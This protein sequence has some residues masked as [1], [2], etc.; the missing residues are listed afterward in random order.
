MP[1]KLSF[2]PLGSI[3]PA[4]QSLSIAPRDDRK[5]LATVATNARESA[6]S[7]LG[8]GLSYNLFVDAAG[9]EYGIQLMLPDCQ[10]ASWIAVKFH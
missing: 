9:P 8:H 10:L 6:P 7:I 5:G 4:L 1:I 3:V 2:N